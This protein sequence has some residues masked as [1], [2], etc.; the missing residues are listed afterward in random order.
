ML[1]YLVCEIG[2]KQYKV[3]PGK[4]INIDWQGVDVKNIEVPVLLKS[5]D[6][7]VEI[8][9]PYLKD[10]IK[11]ECLGEIKGE[12]IRVAKFHAKAN[13]RRVLGFRPKYT[14]AVLP[15]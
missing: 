9:K 13:Y 15:A 2:G 3:V 6:N 11:L 7:K 10:K 5:Q 8:G 4:P 14:K 1:K 12:K